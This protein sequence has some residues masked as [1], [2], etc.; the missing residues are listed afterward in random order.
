M[1]WTPSC[2]FKWYSLVFCLLG[3]HFLYR[4]RNSWRRCL[5]FWPIHRTFSTTQPKSPGKCSPSHSSDSFALKSWD[6]YA[7]RLRWTLASGF[8]NSSLHIFIRHWP[9]NLSTYWAIN[10]NMLYLLYYFHTTHTKV[11]CTDPKEKV[12]KQVD[13]LYFFSIFFYR[14]KG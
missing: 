2:G 12:N 10:T 7:H 6:F 9:H 8:V 13:F 5:M 1:Y 4:T 3:I 14:L 11:D